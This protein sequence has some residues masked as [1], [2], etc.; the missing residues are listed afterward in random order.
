MQPPS[1]PHRWAK[2]AHPPLS[3]R[4]QPFE[5][6]PRLRMYISGA[7]LLPSTV[8][9]LHALDSKQTAT[10][11]PGKESF[12]AAGR[13]T[14]AGIQPP[15]LRVLRKAQIWDFGGS[16]AAKHL[17]FLFIV[18]FSTFC[19]FP[20]GVVSKGYGVEP[21]RP[22]RLPGGYFPGIRFSDPQNNA[23]SRRIACNYEPRLSIDCLSAT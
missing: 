4:G 20:H 19:L 10:M 17:F 22:L 18:V 1:D 9:P 15:F 8:P 12:P 2:I 7:F 3:L 6:R 14:S 23:G 16:Q 13:A 11:P 5:I 21:L